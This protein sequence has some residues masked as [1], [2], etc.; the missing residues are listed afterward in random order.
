M[1]TME[2]ILDEMGEVMFMKRKLFLGMMIA[3]AMVLAACGG[4]MDEAPM[5]AEAPAAVATP[6]P[7]N[8]F[9]FNA[10]N[11][12]LVDVAPAADFVITEA[13]DFPVEQSLRL[14]LDGEGVWNYGAVGG[15]ETAEYASLGIIAAGMEVQ[16]PRMLIQRAWL[17]MGTEEF[18]RTVANLRNV[19]ASYGGYIEISNLTSN[20]LDWD[21]PGIWSRNFSITIRVPVAR[22]EEAMRH[23]EGYGEVFSLNQNTE[24]VTGAVADFQRRMEVRLVEEDRLLELVED[25]TTLN[26]I[27]TL[28]DRLTQVRHHI[29]FYRGQIMGLGDQAAFSTINVNLWDT[30][31]PPEEEEEEEEGDSFGQRISDTFGTSVG[32]VSDVLQGFVIIMAGA[33]IPLLLLG[34]ITF[35]IIVIVRFFSKRAKARAAARPPVHPYY[36]H[37]PAYPTQPAVE[38]PAVAEET[39]QSAETTEEKGE[40]S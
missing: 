28:E 6:A 33:I 14:Q 18:D 38:T 40:E 24:D 17:D 37:Y 4:G 25:A 35:V 21:G 26:Q 32:I 31:E 16:A 8:A 20:W 5:A 36:G 7:G 15:S 1:T 9:G 13:A 2:G 27:F 11:S 30:L 12:R 19:A 3:G 34:A 39:A 23:V 22:F 29:E 10:N